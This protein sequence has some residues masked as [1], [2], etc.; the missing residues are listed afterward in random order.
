MGRRGD[1]ESSGVVSRA[2]GGRSSLALER[3]VA[4]TRDGGGGVGHSEERA[5]AEVAKRAAGRD[6][7]AARG[8]GAYLLREASGALGLGFERGVVLGRERRGVAPERARAARPG[9]DAS[10]G[11]GGTTRRGRAERRGP[12]PMVEQARRCVHPFRSARCVA[13]VRAS[14]RARRRRK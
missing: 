4:S 11:G 7:D 6:G 14:M 3:R 10:R 5:G 13:V 12:E 9:D 8:E 1:R 2:R